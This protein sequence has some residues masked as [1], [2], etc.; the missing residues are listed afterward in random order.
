MFYYTR[1]K[2]D[3]FTLLKQKRQEALDIPYK[4]LT[5][6]STHGCVQACVQST[7]ISNSSLVP[8]LDFAGDLVEMR[9]HINWKRTR[10]DWTDLSSSSR[11]NHKLLC[12][13]KVIFE[14]DCGERLLSIQII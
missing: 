5:P 1:K 8:C 11:E 2:S 9:T 7:G 3:V 4:R 6:S 10:R 13:Q 12:Y 14:P